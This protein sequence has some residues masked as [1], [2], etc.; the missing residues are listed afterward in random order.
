MK[1]I[2]LIIMLMPLFIFGQKV[3]N[4]TKK[5][6]TIVY[7]D[8]KTIVVHFPKNVSYDEVL[9]FAAKKKY[10]LSDDKDLLYVKNNFTQKLMG[11]KIYS[12]KSKKLNL[13]EIFYLQAGLEP[14]IREP[15]NLDVINSR[16]E[17]EDDDR[18]NPKYV[19]CYILFKK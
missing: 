2:L 10:K 9:K 15:G 3:K 5:Y 18:L 11:S 4:E 6:T 14:E 7:L 12:W 19:D 1:K 13:L 8:T 17:F 16:S